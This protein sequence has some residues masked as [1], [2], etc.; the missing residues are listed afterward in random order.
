MPY[1]EQAVHEISHSLGF[2]SSKFDEY[3]TASGAKHATVIARMSQGGKTVSKM[4]TPAVRARSREHFGCDSLEGAEI[5][6]GGGSGT[7]GSHLE[8]RIFM[9]EFMTGTASR[10]PVFSAITL[11]LF[12]D[13]GWYRVNYD[14]AQTIHW[15]NG[16][17]CSFSVRSPQTR[18]LITMN[19]WY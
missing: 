3:R 13:S 11:A 6:D 4:V 17:G 14:G 10:E 15:G 1:H 7:A 18:I 9:N 16:V 5:E 12:E 2:S 19:F 8:K